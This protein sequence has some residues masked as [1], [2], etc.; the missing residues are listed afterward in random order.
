LHSLSEI[1][2]YRI[3]RGLKNLI[4]D[5]N[6]L[7]VLLIGLYDQDLTQYD[8]MTTKNYTGKD[9][10]LL[11]EITKYFEKQLIVTPQILTEV[12]SLSKNSIKNPKFHIYFAKVLDKLRN[13]KEHYI[14]LETMLN[15]EFQVFSKFGFTDMSIVEAAKEI[16]AVIL[17]D[18]LNLYSYCITKKI[19]IIKFSHIKNQHLQEQAVAYPPKA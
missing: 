2:S 8:L 10:K 4:I 15:I 7:L 19:P 5:T 1:K 12:Y 9:F 14:N 13:S 16:N 3:S 11:I 18:E 6:I 17:T